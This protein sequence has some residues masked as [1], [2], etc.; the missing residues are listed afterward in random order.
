[1]AQS[2]SLLLP[3]GIDERFCRDDVAK[4]ESDVWLHY[5]FVNPLTNQP[6]EI[7]I[8][9]MKRATSRRTARMRSV[10]SAPMSLTTAVSRTT[11]P[12]TRHPTSMPSWTATSMLSSKLT[13]WNSTNSTPTLFCKT[14]GNISYSLV[15]RKLMSIVGYS[16]LCKQIRGCLTS[17]GSL[18]F[19]EFEDNTMRI[20]KPARCY[21]L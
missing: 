6:D 2:G 7:V 10:T 9:N 11:V 1:M 12:T 8:E 3:R 19:M 14:A 21:Y 20:V 5:K 15:P 17:V 13:S 4:V 16:L 18:L